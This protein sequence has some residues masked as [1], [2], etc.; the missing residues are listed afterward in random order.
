[1]KCKWSSKVNNELTCSYE[2]HENGYCIF[3]KKKK[4]IN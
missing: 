2:A 3:H 1:M 4:T